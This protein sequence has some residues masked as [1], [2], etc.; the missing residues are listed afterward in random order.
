LNLLYETLKLELAGMYNFTTEEYVF[1]PK[2]SY[3]ITDAL[4]VS[5][6]D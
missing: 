2:I 1:N 3:A 6:G 5:A 4:T